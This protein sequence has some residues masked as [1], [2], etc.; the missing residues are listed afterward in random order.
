MPGKH[1]SSYKM[2]SSGYKMKY[3]GK[4][5]AFPFKESPMKNDDPTS[6]LAE[7]ARE[8]LPEKVK[9]KTGVE[10]A[11]EKVKKF[12][13]DVREIFTGTR[14]KDPNK[15][16]RSININI[17]GGQKQKIKQSNINV[18]GENIDVQKIEKTKKTKK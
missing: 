9:E 13:G 7:R 5:S 10:K 16:K 3:Q 8:F 11:S 2:K 12:R 1:K 6:K 15:K 18:K 4:P 14:E 17:G